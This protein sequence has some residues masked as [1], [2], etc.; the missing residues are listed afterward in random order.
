MIVLASYLCMSNVYA[1][2][3]VAQRKMT[4]M[5]LYSSLKLVILFC[6]W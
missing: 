1:Y 5:D 2:P 6:K 4:G 3:T